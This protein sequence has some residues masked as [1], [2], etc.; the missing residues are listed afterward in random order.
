MTSVRTRRVPALALAVVALFVPTLVGVAL[1]DTTNC[2]QKLRVYGT[3]GD[4][5]FLNTPADEA[6]ILKGGNDN[7]MSNN[8]PE[9]G[10]GAGEDCLIGGDGNDRVLRAGGGD[11]VILG[12]PGNDRAIGAGGNDD[13]NG[14]DGDD[15]IFPEGGDDVINAG[16]GD[17]L[18]NAGGQGSDIIRCGEGNDTVTADATDELHDCEM[19]TIVPLP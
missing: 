15:Q 3:E 16:D 4:D 5:T 1:A 6:F 17:D 19:V 10:A 9:S 14:G 7:V 13:I 8:S 12:G 2:G 11:D 18:I